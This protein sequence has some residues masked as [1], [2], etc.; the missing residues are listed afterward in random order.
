MTSIGGPVVDFRALPKIE[1]HAHLSGSISRQCLHDVWLKKKEVG[2]T[3]L[4]D[5]L[6]EMPLGKHDYDLNTFFPLFSKYIYNLV[7]DAWSLTFT[8]L[9]VLRDFADDGV[10]YLELRTTPRAMPHAGLTKAQYVQTILDA[11]ATFEAETPTPSLRTRL[12][13]SIDRRNTLPEA[14]EVLALA[15]QFQPHGVVGLDLCG[16][17]ARGGIEV[18][19]PVFEEARR[20]VPDLG[21]TLHFA[22][23]AAS[24][25]EE[26]LT[27]LLGWRPDRIGHVIHVSEAVRAAI[28]AR[29]DMGLELCLSCN[30]H[31][32]MI[33]GGFESHHFGEWWQVKETVVVLSTDD[34]GIFGSPLSNEYA[35]VAEHFGLVRAD[36]CALVRRGVDVIFG[37]DKEKQRLRGILWSE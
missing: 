35:L 28:I 19:A 29:G 13:L 16:D 34:V 11:I 5:P 4:Q 33:C 15:R 17:P 10:V 37:G 22:E 20:D 7:N 8:T 23:A 18:F 12:I 32:G 1:L 25:T 21:I 3:D 2:E 9:S 27:M 6:I 14:R 30:V 36:I 26:E 31:A 24:G